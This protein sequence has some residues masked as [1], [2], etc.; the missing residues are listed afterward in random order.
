MGT[1]PF[2]Y[3]HLKFSIFNCYVKKAVSE[4]ELFYDVFLRKCLL[5]SH[6]W[7]F[8]SCQP[9]SCL[10][11]TLFIEIKLKSFSFQI[12]QGYI[13]A[14]VHLIELKCS[15]KL[16]QPYEYTW[17]WDWTYWKLVITIRIG[18]QTTVNLDTYEIAT[19]ANWPLWR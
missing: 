12:W 17:D 6:P 3:I 16:V 1:T 10:I 18:K 9:H 15:I 19:M 14:K 5:L 4:S 8:I 11:H 13:W 2:N 7:H